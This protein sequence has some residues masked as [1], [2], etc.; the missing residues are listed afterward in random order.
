MADID[1]MLDGILTRE[2][3]FVNAPG[4]HGGATKYG[5][6]Q[7]TL[8]AWL[9]RPASVA[10]I[11]A[12]DADTAKAIYGKV[13][14]TGPHLDQLPALI[15]PVMVDAAV[16]SGPVQAIK[17][18]QAVLNANGHGP[19]AEDGAIG[20]RTVQA[21]AAAAAAM[22]TALNRALVEQRRA[23]LRSLAIRDASQ[24]KFEN[25]WMNRCDALEAQYCA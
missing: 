25:G 20:P 10:D 2:G 18:L 15:Q 7:A 11:E 13:Y 5:I 14:V 17:W 9:G 8:G 22:G 3:G 1:V 24:Q 4:D 12:L 6:T 19:L 23:F 21:A 16:N